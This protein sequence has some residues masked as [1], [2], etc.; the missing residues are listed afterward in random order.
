MKLK[1]V[2]R[3]AGAG[4]VMDMEP[5]YDG[6]IAWLKRDKAALRKALRRILTHPQIPADSLQCCR[7]AQVL[8]NP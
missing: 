3:Q 6:E 4:M 5:D 8:V 2:W 7:D 1:A